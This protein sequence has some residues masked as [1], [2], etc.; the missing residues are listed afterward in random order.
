MTAPGLRVEILADPSELARTVAEHAVA[1][2]AAAQAERGRAALVVTGG[3]I[4]ERTLGQL[5]AASRDS[6]LDWSAVDIWWGDE[7]FVASDSADR[8]DTATLAAGLGDL[9][10]TDERIHSAPATDGE[11]GDDL[12]AAAAFYDAEV[13][14]EAFDDPGPVAGIPRLDLILLGIGPDGHCASLFPGHPGLHQN[15]TAIIAVR[16]SPKPPPE[17]ISFTFRG[18]NAIDHV[19]VVAASV[20]KADAAA[21][22]IGGADVESTPSGQPRGLVETVWWLDAAAASKLP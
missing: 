20:D 3:S 10:L 15:D 8:N 12:D 4:L 5:A 22:A 16:D 18:L 17:R 1:V 11:V 6:G 21:R 7:R 13:A 9:G 2:L 19:W 14:A